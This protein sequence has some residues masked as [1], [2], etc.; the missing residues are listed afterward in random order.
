MGHATSLHL[1]MLRFCFC[2]L[3]KLSP[4][5]KIWMATHSKRVGQQKSV[6]FSVLIVIVH[7]CLFTEGDLLCCGFEIKK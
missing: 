3:Q 1:K 5:K 7:V 6:F 2:F 4:W